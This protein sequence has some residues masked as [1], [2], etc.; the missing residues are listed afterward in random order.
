MSAAAVRYSTPAQPRIYG[1][2]ELA[3]AAGCTPRQLQ[4]WDERHLFGRRIVLKGHRRVWN[5][6]HIFVVMF[7]AA[8]R[9][10]GISLQRVRRLLRSNPLP[11][12]PGKYY[13]IV[14]YK[15]GSLSW[16]VFAEDALQ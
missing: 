3:R 16:Q 13:G 6:D 12:R 11:S 9:R 4:W 7:A 1:T 8:L 15:R 14:G 2:V 5:A 10:K